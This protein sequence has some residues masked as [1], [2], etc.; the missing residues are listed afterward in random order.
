M[1][2][3]CKIPGKL[4]WD[5]PSDLTEMISEITKNKSEI[6][7]LELTHCSIGTEC[8]KKLSEAISL[9]EKL[10]SVNCNSFFRIFFEIMH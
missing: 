1:K 10:T 9:C 4:K 8:A 7:I 6:A 2:Y 3:T 5:D